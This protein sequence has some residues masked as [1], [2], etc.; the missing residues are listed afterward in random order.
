MQPALPPG[1]R[2]LALDAIDSTNDEAQRLAA[3]G[4]HG[5]LWIWALS[6]EKGRGRRGRDWVSPPGNLYLT[7][8]FPLAAPA[9]VAAQVGFVAA[10]AV[11]DFALAAL[12]H[13]Y[14][15]RI[16]L[17]W[18]NDVLIDGAKFSGILAETAASPGSAS[19]IVLLGCGINLAGAP[20]GTPYPVTALS[21]LG[22]DIVPDLALESFAGFFQ[23]W[24]EV[25][26]NG[27]G[28]DKIRSAWLAHALGLGSPVRGENGL[29]GSFAG[30]AENG[31]MIVALSSGEKRILHSG[32][33]RFA[34]VAASSA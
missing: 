26:N 33:V 1:H 22:A 15:G 7:H 32:E 16:L 2:L 18:P 10:L 21:R 24:F 34:S 30:L 23:Q 14:S 8:V 27:T 31:A 28:F 5:P 13:E 25:W 9:A 3:A 19:L 4:E 6:Q 29:E 20:E 11:R 12:G 17:K